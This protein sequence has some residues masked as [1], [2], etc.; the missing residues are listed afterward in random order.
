MSSETFFDES[1]VRSKVKAKIVSDYFWAWAKVI[2]PSVK[3]RGEKIAY[4]DL[5][6]GKGRYQDGTKSTPLLVLER[7]ISDANMCKYL[8]TVFNDADPENAKSLR[9]E[10]ANLPGIK[11]LRYP[12]RVEAEEIGNGFV[13]RF[14]NLKLVPTF[15]FIDP[16]GYKGLSLDLIK[17]VI[18]N[19]GCDC[20]FFFNY[21]RI[22]M[23][24]NN[25]AVE[26]HINVLFGK[27]RAERLREG[28]KGMPVEGREAAIVEALT[29][30]IQSLGATYVLPF[31]FKSES[32]NRTSHH[33]V[34]ATKHQLGYRIMKEIMAKYSSEE[35]QGVASFGY[36]PASP[37][38]PLLFE[39]N[40]PLDE[41]MDMLLGRFA[42]Q[43]LTVQEIYDQHNV[44]YPYIMKNYKSALLDMESRSVIQTDPPF[45]QRPVRLG[46]KTMGDGVK[47]TFP[48]PR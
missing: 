35:H 16:W 38:Q 45:E 20:V 39:L 48:E 26:G 36:C 19:W 5:F 10:I 33:L 7:A 25:A 43:T 28:L 24:L 42:G 47:V 31:C 37:N 9:N 8:A 44:G 13:E 18:K 41:L 27:D 17:L 14:A 3:N 34:F 12:P 2:L 46:K 15:F 4:I 32:G 30:A 21:N 40:R 23:G 22:N 29:E 11:S 1:T 6:A